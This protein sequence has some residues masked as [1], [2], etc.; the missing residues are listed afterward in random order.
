[1]IIIS[2]LKIK[3]EE[4]QLTQEEV[5][6]RIGVEQ[7]TVSQWEKG[8]RIPRASNLIALAKLFNCTVD[9]LLTQE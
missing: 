9:E 4:A 3:R 5:A 6:S 7:N 1:M 8:V 2:R